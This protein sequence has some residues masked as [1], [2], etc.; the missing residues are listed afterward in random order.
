MWTLVRGRQYIR[1]NWTIRLHG[2]PVKGGAD[3]RLTLGRDL[4]RPPVYDDELRTA[5]AANTYLLGQVLLGI[6]TPC[7]I[8]LAIVAPEIRTLVGIVAV[9][10]DVLAALVL[11]M[12]GFGLLTS[13]TVVFLFGAWALFTWVAWISGGIYSPSICAQL[14]IVALAA[15]TYGWRWALP[16]TVF[17]AVTIGALSLAQLRG[18]VPPSMLAGSPATY[19]ASVLAY[20][21]ALALVGAVMAARRSAR[22]GRIISEL[23]QRRDAEQELRDVIDHAPFGAFLC[24]LLHERRLRVTHANLVASVALGADASQ[25]VGGDLGDVFAASSDSGLM[26]LFRRV[27]LTGE[28]FDAD[29]VPIYSAGTQRVLEVHAYRTQP[30]AIAVFFSDVTQK[31]QDEAEIQ[32]MAFHD[33]LTKLP[34]RKL[35]LDRL[36]VAIAGARRRESGGA[37]L[38]IDLDEFKPINDRYGHGFGDLVLAAVA[39]RLEAMARMSDT[40]ARIGGDEFTVLMPDVTSKEQVETVARKIV[41]AFQEPFEI[42]GRAINVTASVGVAISTDNTMGPATLVEHADMAMYEM[43]RQGRNGYRVR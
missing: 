37:L 32:R 40:V 34:N 29:D 12:T 27:A 14:L 24:E 35:L 7:L 31:R 21:L 16:A 39:A 26:D 4:L 25:F 6:V 17:S 11:V 1:D 10:V 38:F 8:A 36:A 19:G 41:A 30:G 23:E 3:A 22:Q 9:G 20:L 18:V 42:D 15:M 13:A 28:V 43:K 5:R 33:E 2:E